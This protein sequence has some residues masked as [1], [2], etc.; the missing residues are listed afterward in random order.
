LQPGSN[1]GDGTRCATYGLQVWDKVWV[2]DPSAPLSSQPQYFLTSNHAFPWPGTN[3][4]QPGNKTPLSSSDIVGTVIQSIPPTASDGLFEIAKVK[5][6]GS[7]TFNNAPHAQAYPTEPALGDHLFVDGAGDM[8][9]GGAV[10]HGGDGYYVDY[11]IWLDFVVPGGTARMYDQ[12][13]V[14]PY[15]PSDTLGADGNSG[16]VFYAANSVPV[17]IQLAKADWT[18][19][20]DTYTGAIVSFLN[21]TLADVLD[22]LN[23]SNVPPSPGTTPPTW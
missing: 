5:S 4:Y 16:A 21:S 23:C 20:G 9:F 6:N 1:V 11:A 13:I 2:G 7:R 19:L 15:Y 3:V 17:G 12:M 10:T 22:K 8:T 14:M 18:Y